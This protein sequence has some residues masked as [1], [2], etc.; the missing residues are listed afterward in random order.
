[1]KRGELYLVQNTHSDDPKKQRVYVVVSRQEFIDS[2]Y[3]TVICAPVYSNFE[4]L[5]TQVSIGI[6]EGLKHESAIRCDELISIAK[7]RLSNYVGSLP[8][9]KLW[10]LDKAL[11]FAL[12]LDMAASFLDL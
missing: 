12:G 11:T 7:Y 9:A 3:S 10:K 8:E 5:S 1:V 4:G 6:N 2:Y